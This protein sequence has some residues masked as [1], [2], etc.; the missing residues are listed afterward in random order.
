[1]EK[2]YEF[3]KKTKQIGSVTLHRIK[4]LRKFNDVKKGDLGG[5]IEKEYNL[6]N[7][8]NAWVSGNARVSENARV[9]GNAIVSGN[10][11]VFENA[12]VSGNAWV[13]EDAKVSGNAWVSE[14]AIVF[15]EG[16]IR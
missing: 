9:S 15:R 1:M 13:S 5:W 16:Y 4:A 14:N 2:K 11:R 6:S 10:A 12:I 3:T 7:K 8:D